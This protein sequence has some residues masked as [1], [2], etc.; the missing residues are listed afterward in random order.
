MIVR[1]HM[2]EYTIRKAISFEE[3]VTASL[4]LL[5]KGQDILLRGQ[6]DLTVAFGQLH[7]RTAQLEEDGKWKTWGMRIVKAGLPFIAGA[8]V[9]R[10]PQL[11]ELIGS[12]VQ[13]SGAVAPGLVP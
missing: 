2:Q 4:D 7:R 5:N 8:L 1:W 10:F 6:A 13:A 9:S 11:A 3:Q 12:I